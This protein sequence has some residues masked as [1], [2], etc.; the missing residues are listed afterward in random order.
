MPATVRRLLGAEELGLRLLTPESSLQPGALNV[1]V[2]WV[3]NSDLPDPTPFL[4]ERMV[5][6]TTGTQFATGDQAAGPRAHPDFYHD[7]VSRLLARG[8]AGLGFGTDVVR[9]GTPDALLAACA[10]AGL[11]LFEVPY[12][13]PFIAIARLAADIAAQDTYARNTWALA[14]QRAISLAALRPNGL[15][16][17]LAELSRQLGHWVALFDATG[18]LDR[19]FPPDALPPETAQQ[20]SAEAATLLRGARRSSVTVSAGGER[21][22]LQ[23]LG[24]RG[25]LRGALAFGDE[26]RLDQAS[27][28]VVT[29]V[30]ALA[31][32]ALEQNHALDRARD[33]LR[34]GL[35]RLLLGGD[36]AM[37][38]EIYRQTWG[39]F[40]A[41]PVIVAVAEAPLPRLEAVAEYIERRAENNSPVFH[42]IAR[43]RIV[44]CTETRS[45]PALELLAR[46]FS[47]RLGISDP[48]AYADLGT[49]LSQ[50]ERARDRAVATGADVVTFKT[51][52]REGVLGLLAGADAAEVARS[53]LEPLTG[54]DA[55]HGTQ[56]VLSVRAWLEANGEFEASARVLGVHRHTVRARIAQAEQLLGRDLGTFRAR[57][58][59]W[60]ALLAAADAQGA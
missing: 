21:I 49:A 51:V 60:A 34:A 1:P 36:V 55:A 46:E 58:D 14:A 26:H 43:N 31:G 39:D 57:A 32:L 20:V 37:V 53:V 9:E 7:Y 12:R 27:Q 8:V 45:Q 16:A 50:A 54:Y 44:L 6:L 15:A 3:H 22:T 29:S 52:S 2:P 17:T 35:W 23:T 42:S 5:L 19:I 38:E 30:I 33:H 13:T 11:P 47:L 56:L 48:T 10:A 18:T 4:S 25:R 59:L 24:G 40:P 28:Q 41:A